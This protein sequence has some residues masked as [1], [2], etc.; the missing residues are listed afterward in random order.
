MTNEIPSM[1][2]TETVSTVSTPGS[3]GKPV[4]IIGKSPNTQDLTTLYTFN[5]YYEASLSVANGGVG[6]EPGE[7]D[8]PNELLEAIYDV[9]KESERRYSADTYGIS[10]IYAVNLGPSPTTQDWIDAQTLA[11][12][13]DDIGVELYVGNSTISFMATTATHLS[14]IAASTRRRL[15]VFTVADGA[16][17]EQASAYTDPDES[18]YVSST[19]TFIE[20][21]SHQAKTAAKLAYTPYNIDPSFYAYRTVTAAQITD[22]KDSQRNTLIGSGILC[23]MK[24]DQAYN[25]VRMAEPVKMVSTAYRSVD[26]D[27][28]ADSN[29]FQRIM[30]DHIL[31]ERDV[32]IRGEL[33]HINS[34]TGYPIL[35]ELLNSRMDA[36][37]S[38]GLLESYSNTVQEDPDDPNGIKVYTNLVMNG[39]I[40]DVAIFTNLSMS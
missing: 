4:L 27:V 13:I 9:F 35:E 17:V 37:V 19:R 29:A 32:V 3:G 23:S 18:S 14:T 39:S 8:D 26:G 15:A 31:D 33:K 22:L 25:T 36:Y 10:K 28:P 12:E 6:P 1:M 11:A 7:G 34:A 30:A 21:E 24:S 2:D 5:N 16:T 40:Y 20:Y 38:V